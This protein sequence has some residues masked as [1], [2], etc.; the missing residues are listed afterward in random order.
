MTLTK[1]NRLG[2]YK[3][4][5]TAKQLIRYHHLQQVSSDVVHCRPS[6]RRDI[7]IPLAAYLG[8]AA[9]LTDMKTQLPLNVMLLC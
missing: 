5:P 6:R 3:H 8:L 9:K 4:S 2:S 1:D 7:Q